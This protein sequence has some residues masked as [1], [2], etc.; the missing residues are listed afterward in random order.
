MTNYADNNLKLSEHFT[1]AEATASYVADRFGIDNRLPSYLIDNAQ[2]VAEEILEPMRQYFNVP[3]S[4]LSWYRAPEVCRRIGSSLRSQHTEGLAVDIRL[5][6]YSI[7]DVAQYIYE[8]EEFDQLIIEFYNKNNPNV[9]W[10]HVSRKFTNNRNQFLIY[11]G[12]KY[13][14]GKDAGILKTPA[15]TLAIRNEKFLELVQKEKNKYL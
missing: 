4:P 11:D 3:F 7:I 5:R 9:G 10:V 13:F 14:N 15:E 8:W 2:L 6:N 1:V 12:K